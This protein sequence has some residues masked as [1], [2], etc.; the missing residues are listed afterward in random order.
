[1]VEHVRVV[2]TTQLQLER[3]LMATSRSQFVSLTAVTDPDMRKRNNPFVGVVRKVS[4]VV[5]VICWNYASAVNRQR[6]REA[7]S[8]ASTTRFESVPRHWG[9]RIKGTPLVSH[10]SAGDG[11]TVL[12]LEVKVQS[13]TVHYFD[14]DTHC[15]I[16]RD[17]LH[18]FLTSRETESNR[19]GVDR[20]I[21][22]RD[23]R[24]TNIAELTLA[25]I[26]YTIAPAA[27]ELQNYFPK[28][29][30]ARSQSGRARHATS[31]R[32][33]AKGAT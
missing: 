11:Q 23:F 29:K 21:V 2:S 10:V 30:A 33:P 25:G 3:I 9:S 31:K 20:Q 4:M 7:G 32:Q 22:L 6:V 5:G 24:L 19:Q 12:Y 17:D 8:A 26:R 18:P 13:R 15:S 1:M 28:A 16:N 27:T 14:R